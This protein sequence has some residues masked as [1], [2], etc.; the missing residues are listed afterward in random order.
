MVFI[1]EKQIRDKAIEVIHSQPKDK[2]FTPTAIDDE[3]VAAGSDHCSTNWLQ[4]YLDELVTDT[5]SRPVNN[6]RL[7]RGIKP[8]KFYWI[9]LADYPE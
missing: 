9:D 8:N 4:A 1:P 2:K 6:R 5:A 3:M 7:F